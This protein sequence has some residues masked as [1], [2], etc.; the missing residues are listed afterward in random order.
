M[1]SV[2]LWA[3]CLLMCS[4]VFLSHWRIGVGIW[5]LVLA[6]FWMGLV[7]VLRQRPLGRLSSINVPWDQECSGGSKSWAWVSHLRGSGSMPMEV[8]NLTS[9]T[10]QQ[11]DYQHSW[12]RQHSAAQ[13]TQLGLHQR[14]LIL[15]G[16]PL[17]LL[18][19]AWGDFS[20]RSGLIPACSNSQCVELPLGSTVCSCPGHERAKAKFHWGS[21]ALLG[22]GEGRIWPPHMSCPGE[23]L[24]SSDLLDVDTI[25]GRSWVLPGERVPRKSSAL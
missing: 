4:T 9:H 10:A 13:N 7:L 8:P 6:G 22:W 16:R 14:P 5:A 1:G 25:W 11:T 21:L 23:C 20:V 24:C 19:A 12:W 18:W 2:W 17:D 15:P 3:A